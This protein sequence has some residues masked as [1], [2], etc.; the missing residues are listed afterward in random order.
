MDKINIIKVI[1]WEEVYFQLH[2]F[3]VGLVLF[4]LCYAFISYTFFQTMRSYHCGCVT[5]TL[6]AEWFVLLINAV[7]QLLKT[8]NLLD[9]LITFGVGRQER[10]KKAARAHPYLPALK[11]LF[12]QLPIDILLLE[13]IRPV[14]FFLLLHQLAILPQTFTLQL[15]LLIKLPIPLYHPIHKLSKKLRI[16]RKVQ[17]P[18]SMF[19]EF[20]DWPVVDIS[21]A[22]L[23][24]TTALDDTI[25]PLRTNCLIL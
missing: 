3:V 13:V 15:S 1:L 20:L 14:I 2:C 21:I 4:N 24:H 12:N 18:I 22:V 10:L 16:V 11:Q 19:F 5:F 17:V 23:Y 6:A 9:V 25:C 7:I 8:E